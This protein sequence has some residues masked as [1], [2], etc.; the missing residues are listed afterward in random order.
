MMAP[1]T[2]AR[3]EGWGSMADLFHPSSLI[4]H[5]SSL[6]ASAID[7][8]VESMLTGI[9][10]HHGLLGVGGARALHRGWTDTR[11]PENPTLEPGLVPELVEP[12][13]RASAH[14]KGAMMSIQRM[15]LTGA[16]ILVSRGVKV[17][18]AAPAP[19]P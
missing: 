10:S 15:K 14:P 19:Y 3:D 13:G 7:A 6:I 2:E 12:L 9:E 17:L 18:Q 11:G 4:P 8:V 1:D 5:P 16:S